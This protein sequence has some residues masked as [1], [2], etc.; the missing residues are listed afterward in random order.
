[1]QTCFSGDNGF[2]GLPGKNNAWSSSRT[3][4][5]KVFQQSDLIVF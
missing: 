5:L 1:M 3:K 4:V 2:P